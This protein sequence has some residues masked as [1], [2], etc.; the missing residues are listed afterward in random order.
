M[1]DTITRCPKCHTS[2]RITEAHLKSAKGAVRCGS[3]LNIFNARQFL[4]KQATAPAKSAAKAQP[5]KASP[6]PRMRHTATANTKTPP[7][8]ITTPDEDDNL[9]ISDDMPLGEGDT[10]QGA[11][12][13]DFNDNILYSK[14]VG[15]RESNLFER[16]PVNDEDDDAPTS[17]ESWALDLLETDNNKHLTPEQAPVAPEHDQTQYSEHPSSDFV[18]DIHHYNEPTT[19]ENENP[20][21]TESHDS[22]FSAPEPSL[23]ELE[24][25]AEPDYE[26]RQTSQKQFLHAIEP[27]PVE[28]S[29]K[30][31]RSFLES[32]ILWFPLIALMATALFAQVAWLQFDTLNRIE[33][34]RSYYAHAC[35]YLN[36]TLAPLHDRTAIHAVNLVVRSHPSQSG[37]LVVDAV[38]QNAAPYPQSFPA[39]DLVFTDMQDNAIAARRFEPAEYLGGEMAGKNSMPSRQPIHIALEIVD[40][41]PSAVGYR[42]AIAN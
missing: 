14:T 17:D 6:P 8:A 41:G 13:A 28:L 5:K 12:D 3:C 29:Y 11:Y 10:D 24:A 15:S 38:L 37:A 21:P 22:I 26:T 23:A 4:V 35:E 7:P 42:I 9:L 30:K 33:P 1:T 19:N 25:F 39:L 34:Y 31:S 27:E 36:C 32:K 2:F 16:D 18:E 20:A 40:P